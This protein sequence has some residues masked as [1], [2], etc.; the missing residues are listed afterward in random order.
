MSQWAA[1]RTQVL[2]NLIGVLREK[3][4]PVGEK[5]G[6]SEEIVVPPLVY[7]WGMGSKHKI[8]EEGRCMYLK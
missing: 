8:Q 7:G 5:M 6:L 4:L 2:E 1:E 3:A